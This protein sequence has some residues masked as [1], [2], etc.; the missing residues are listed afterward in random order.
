MILYG[1]L[2]LIGIATIMAFANW[3]AGVY[4]FLVIGL[5]QDP[6]RKM[7]PGVPGLLVLSTVP[8]WF[9]V[10]LIFPLGFPAFTE[11]QACK[12]L[13]KA[14]A[15]VIA[16]DKL[17]KPSERDEEITEIHDAAETL[18]DQPES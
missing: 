10:V 14:V 16:V 1:F 13:E 15:Q 17:N 11:Y 4:W 9:A 5:L 12:D 2:A 7:V 3:R 18:P 8:V 6:V